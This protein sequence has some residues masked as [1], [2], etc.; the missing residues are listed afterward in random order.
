MNS[1]ISWIGG[2]KCEVLNCSIEELI[3]YKP[4]KVPRTGKNLIIEEHG[5]RKKR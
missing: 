4:N 1:F 2:K 5:N 3:E